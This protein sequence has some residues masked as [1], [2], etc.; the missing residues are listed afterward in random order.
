MLWDVAWQNIWRRRGRTALTIL[1][2][3]VVAQLYVT[4]A[5]MIESYEQN[6]QHQL[7][8]MVGQV[9]V[10][11]PLVTAD[12]NEGFPSFSS[13]IPAGTA[14]QVLALDGVDP[15]ASSAVLFVA[16]ALAALSAAWPAWQSMRIEPL[17]ALR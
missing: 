7:S 6:L 15:A 14:A 2:I 17:E 1:G 8:A 9:A 11:R 5:S 16:L 10:Q 13:S 3:A 12:E 4:M